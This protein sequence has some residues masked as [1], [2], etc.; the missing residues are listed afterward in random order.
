MG[1]AAL[2]ADFALTSENISLAAQP[3][4]GPKAED[5]HCE[6]EHL[7]INTR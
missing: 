7:V 2:S 5:S 1:S 6:Q 3:T 4:L